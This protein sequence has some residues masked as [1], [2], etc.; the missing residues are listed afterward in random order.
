MNYIYIIVP[1]IAVLLAQISKFFIKK[2]K[3]QWSWKNLIAYSGMPSGHAA[4][5]VS[6][7]T[8]I[9][10]EIGINSAIFALAALVT[11]LSIRDAAGIRQYIGRQGKIINE[12]VD[13]LSDD[14]YLD[15]AYP[16]LIEKVG[17]TPK[18]LFVGSLIGLI[19][20]TL[21]HYLLS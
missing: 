20:G 18:Q 13:D 14:A 16:S 11:F 2:N 12:I 5:T 4:V 15:G 8:V 9:G 10:F 19:V 1:F 3:L 17:H 21:G 7:T 6:L